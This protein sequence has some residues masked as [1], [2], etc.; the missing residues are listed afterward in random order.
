M[1]VLTDQISGYLHACKSEKRLSPDTLKA[2]RIDLAQ[3]AAFAQE[4]VVDKALL[5]RYAAHLNQNFSPRSV[6]RK[7]ASVRAFYSALE[8]LD[9][10]EENPFRRFQLHISYPKELPRVIPTSKVEALLRN[11]YGQYKSS[12]DRWALRDILVLELLFDTGMRVSELCK[13]TPET[14]QLTPSGLWLLIHGKGRKERVLQIATA[15]VVSLAREYWSVFE[16]DIHAAGFILLN[17]RN[18]PL[19]PQG[20]RQLI[21]RHIQAAAVQ[22]HFTPHMFRH[23]FATAL[24]DG[25]A[26][27]RYIQTLLGHSSISTTEIYT[28]VATGRQSAILAQRHPRNTMT[29]SA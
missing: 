19:T 26:D 24:L 9:A 17:R 29:F 1:S 18:R 6:K 27:I 11:A 21:S 12:S 23:T 2:Y 16:A 10:V 8:E 13:L 25:G 28:H 14:F 5:G 7:L 20:V 22:G 3:F 4:G 15:E